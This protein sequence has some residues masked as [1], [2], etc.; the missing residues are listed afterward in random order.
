MYYVL[1][2]I[3]E[4][5]D[6]LDERFSGLCVTHWTIYSVQCSLPQNLTTLCCAS[7][8][9][10]DQVQWPVHNKGQYT[11]SQI[12]T[13]HIFVSHEPRIGERRKKALT[14][15]K[16]ISDRS[17]GCRLC[18]SASI[19]NSHSSLFV[20]SGFRSSVI[21]FL[22]SSQ[23]NFNSLTLLFVSYFILD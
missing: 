15:N 5:N 12:C 14:T 10:K 21:G 8:R 9:F 18:I 4:L 6:W 23:Y 3:T 2:R 20:Y 1:S 22:L 19:F 17:T 16:L 13:L 11:K 7:S